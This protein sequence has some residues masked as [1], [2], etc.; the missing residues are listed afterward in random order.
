MAKAMA[1]LARDKM[2]ASFGIGIEGKIQ[3][4]KDEKT[5]K[6]F[7]AIV[8]PKPMPSVVRDYSGRIMAVAGRVAYTAL[9]ELRKMLEG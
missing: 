8:G 5:A 9:F 2:G 1:A 6:V 7:I 4:V 3:T